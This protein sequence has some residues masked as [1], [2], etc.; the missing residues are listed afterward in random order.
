MKNWKAQKTA[1]AERLA[2]GHRFALEDNVE[3][4]SPGGYAGV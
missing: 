3:I 2:D 4:A 1:L